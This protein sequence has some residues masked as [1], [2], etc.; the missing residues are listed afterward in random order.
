MGRVD[1]APERGPALCPGMSWTGELGL[2]SYAQSPAQLEDVSATGSPVP[3][4]DARRCPIVVDSAYVLDSLNSHLEKMKSNLTS[5]R[6][7]N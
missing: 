4:T 5:H 1:G 7:H 6:A 3:I 2:C